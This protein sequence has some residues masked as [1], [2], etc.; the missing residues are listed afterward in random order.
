MKE[1]I[2]KLINI[3][4]D[5][6]IIKSFKENNPE[7]KELLLKYVDKIHEE[8]DI[9]ASENQNQ[10]EIINIKTEIKIAELYNQIPNKEY[11]DYAI[12]SLEEILQGIGSSILPDKLI[13]DIF[14]LIKTWKSEIK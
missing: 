6:N 8:A 14:D 11:K 7:S 3:T 5:Q 4:E 9:E 12:Q 10:S 13:N 2:E 1:Q